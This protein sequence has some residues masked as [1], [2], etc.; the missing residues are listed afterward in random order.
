M[1]AEIIDFRKA[2]VAHALDGAE[3]R[4]VLKKVGASDMTYEEVTVLDGDGDPIE[5]GSPDIGF[6]LV[7]AV[8]GVAA[9][10]HHQIRIPQNA[11]EAMSDEDIAEALTGGTMSDEDLSMRIAAAVAKESAEDDGGDAQKKV[12]VDRLT[13]LAVAII[14][15]GLGVLFSDLFL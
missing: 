5:V 14:G 8:S 12:L 4:I 6:A 11:H 7:N 1:S 3:I 9:M 15:M 10:I 2:A 13:L